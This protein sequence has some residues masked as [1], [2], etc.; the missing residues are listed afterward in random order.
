MN[1]VFHYWQTAA[2]EALYQCAKKIDSLDDQVNDDEIVVNHQQICQ[3]VRQDIRNFGADISLELY[4]ETDLQIAKAI[5]SIVRETELIS[6]ISTPFAINRYKINRQ[7][8]ELKEKRDLAFLLDFFEVWQ[9]ADELEHTWLTECLVSILHINK[10]EIVEKGWIP[11]DLDYESEEAD[12]AFSQLEKAVKAIEGDNGYSATYPEERNGIVAT[13]R[14][15][16][17]ELKHHNDLALLCF[18]QM[19]IE[20]LHQVMK[21]VG[22]N[23]TGAAVKGALEAIKDWVKDNVGGILP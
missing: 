6:E 8:L 4:N 23:I 13:L 2:I 16:L 7:F 20:P 3:I 10:N 21:R 14:M 12:I 1:E 9:A 15:G 5:S 11:L 18:K 19:I 22:D 17:S